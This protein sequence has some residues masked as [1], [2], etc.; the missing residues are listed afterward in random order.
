M[1]P[2]QDPFKPLRIVG[3]GGALHAK[4]ST[5]NALRIVLAAAQRDGAEVTLLGGEDIDLPSYVPGRIDDRGLARRLID[6]LRTADGV[7]IGSP[8]YH[9]SVSGLVKNALDYLEE[10]RDDDRPYLDGRGVGCLATAG[11]WQ[12]AVTTMT[13]LRSITHALRG[14]PTPLGVS[15]CTAEPVFDSDGRCVSAA[16]ERQLELLAGQV[17]ELARMARAQRRDFAPGPD[18]SRP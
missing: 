2:A 14:W 10:L 15:I 13:S 3:L 16:V 5:E 9:G 4:S 17:V 7:V 1:L 11:G 8:G 18:V 12:A 6:V